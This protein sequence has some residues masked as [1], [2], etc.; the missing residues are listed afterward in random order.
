METLI[1]FT[2]YRLEVLQ[3]YL[4]HCFTGN[5]QID[6]EILNQLIK[7]VQDE[8]SSLESSDEAD[9]ISKHFNNTLGHLKLRMELPEGDRD[10]YI[11]LKL[12]SDD[13]ADEVI[14]KKELESQ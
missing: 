1:S 5:D 3:I 13:W 4:I 12:N 9:Q 8:L 2:N 7:K 14:E 6:V 10:S 11:G